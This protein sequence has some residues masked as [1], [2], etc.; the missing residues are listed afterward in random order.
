MIDIL[1]YIGA[2]YVPKFM[3]TWSNTTVYEALSVV[4]DGLGTSYISGIPVPAGTPLTNTDYWHLYGATSGAIINLQNQI[5]KIT[6]AFITPEMYGAVGDGITDDT[7]AIQAAIDSSNDCIVF[8]GTYL[9]KTDTGEAPLT[10]GQDYSTY[11]IKI[12]SPKTLIFRGAKVKGYH[13][14]VS[15]TD[16]YF[17]TTNSALTVIGLDYDGQR[18]TYQ[19][20]YG[21]QFNASDCI[22]KDCIFQNLGGSFAVFNGQKNTRIENITVNNIWADNVGNSMFFAWCDYVD[23]SDIHL[24]NASEGFDFDKYSTNVN[25]DGV[26]A[27]VA[28]GGGADA[29]IEINGGKKFNISN[30]VA[31]DYCDGILL[32]GKTWDGVDY[33]TEDIN[34]NNCTFDTITGYG[35]L[36]GNAIAG[37]QEVKNVKISNVNVHAATLAGFEIVGENISLDNCEATGCNYM[38]LFITTKAKNITI[39]NFFSKNNTR[40]LIDCSICEGLLTLSNIIDDETGHVGYTNQISGYEHLKISN[41]QVLNEDQADF[42]GVNN[43]MFRI[44]ESSGIADIDG[45]ITSQLATAQVII[46]DATKRHI[47][48]SQLNNGTWSYSAPDVIFSKSAFNDISGAIGVNTGTI[49]ICIPTYTTA[50][51][52]L[53]VR[54]NIA[55][56]DTVE[57]K[58]I[59]LA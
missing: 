8:T 31:Y 6:E 47:S 24:H 55:T 26:T 45:F 48:N 46:T 5:D 41:L 42:S 3:G 14:L 17:I 43:R 27:N 16:A 12:T 44:A 9:V 11:A 49:V 15:T 50:E 37:V 58:Q 30:I 2:R 21:I 13:N 19:Y 53:C 40:G 7:A 38:A 32:N 35:I 10:D 25:I 33:I 39:N 1:Q 56:S 59:T 28:R 57:W 52:H 22:L 34:I 23:I 29:L 18:P 54:G 36:G 51:M 4:D 20:Q